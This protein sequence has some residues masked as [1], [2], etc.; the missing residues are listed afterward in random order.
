LGEEK[1]LPANGAGNDTK[2]G[3]FVQ[4]SRENQKKLVKSAR[5]EKAR[6]KTPQGT[7]S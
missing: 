5:W 2:G 3:D 7:L 1:R 6:I 4:V